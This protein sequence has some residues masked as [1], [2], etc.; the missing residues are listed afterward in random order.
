MPEGKLTGKVA[1]ITG[2]GGG[3]GQGIA[4]KFAGEGAKVAICDINL[5][6]AE[7][8]VAA[9]ENDGGAGLAF[10]ADV[11]ENSALEAFVTATVERFGRLDIWVGNAG[12]GGGTDTVKVVEAEYRRMIDINLCGVFFGAQFAGRQMIAQGGG[13]RIINMASVAGYRAIAARAA[14]C[15]AKAGVIMTTWV[16]AEEWAKHGIRVNSIS[17]GYAD[18]PLF[19]SAAGSGSRMPLERLLARVPTGELITVE[20]VARAALYLAS[21]DSDAVSGL[22]L[23]IDGALSVGNI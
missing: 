8:V 12:I 20:Q 6:A 4:H 1:A 16:L 15:A 22:D 13:G 9:I 19:W 14:Y 23:R 18:T 7:A 3:F 17:P 11:T 21:D 5:P 10:A 2:G